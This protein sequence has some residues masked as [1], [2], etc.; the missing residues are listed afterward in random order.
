[1]MVKALCETLNAL[2]LSHSSVNLMLLMHLSACCDSSSALL[3]LS[4]T[5]SS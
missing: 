1:M 3:Q 4:E 5:A 2:K